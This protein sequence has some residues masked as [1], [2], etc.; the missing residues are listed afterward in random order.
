MRMRLTATMR[1]LS[2]SRAEEIGCTRFFRNPKVTVGEILETAAAA[3]A[4]A[5]AG[6]HVLL[7]EDTSEINYQAKSKRKRG[8]G[9]V[10]NGSDVG[11]FVHPALAVDAADGSIL[12]L[13]G[14]TIWRRRTA[15]QANYQCLPIEDKESYRWLATAKAA[16]QA[17]VATTQCTVI[18]D[19]EADIYEVLARV[20]DER[21][22]VL[23][24]AHHDRALTVKGGRLFAAIAGWSEAGR[25]SFKMPARPG[26]PARQVNL[27]VRFGK[28]TLR[29]PR[30]G[31]DKRDPRQITI[32]VV[33]A[34][35]IDP[36][37]PK[38]AVVWRLL[39]THAVTSLADAA[40]M[41]ELYRWR[42]AI[43]QVFRTLKSQGLDLEESL[44]ADG[45]ALERLAA[46]AL[47]A[48]VHAMQLV[49]GRGEAGWSLQAARLFGPTEITVLQALISKF[50]GK[51]AKQKN[52]H[53]KLSL[54]WAAW[55]IARLGGWNGYAR[56][57]P[58]GPITFI[59]GLERFHAIVDGFTL[60]NNAH[61]WLQ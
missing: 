45:D 23:V 41:I 61:V 33:E 57:R 51:T 21:T 55:P 26:R 32:N 12:G 27:A 35:E 14:A 19:R 37:S 25:L 3:T 56:E 15:K 6:R 39:T 43:E 50:E 34:R 11:L 44:L 20:P 30:P 18:A 24:R 53:P 47:V 38:E 8:L 5:A 42:W 60:A 29:Q 4:Q 52:P 17:L 40:R 22:H 16:R 7:I 31:A 1:Q 59:R 2:D 13:A 10:G 49:H 54:A 48:S 46:V 9:K 36:P 58:P 28:V